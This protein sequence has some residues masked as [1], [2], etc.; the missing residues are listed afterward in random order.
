MKTERAEV[1][2]PGEKAPGRPYRPFQYLKGLIKTMESN[3]Q[4]GQIVTEQWGTV[5]N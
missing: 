2:Q 5:L 4:H 3:F 1:V